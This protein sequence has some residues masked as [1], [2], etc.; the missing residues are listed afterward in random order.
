MIEVGHLFGCLPGQLRRELV[1]E[2]SEL[3]T[4]YIEGKWRA[5]GL[6]AGRFCEVIYSVIKGHS[7]NKYPEKT[8]KPS[9]FIGK[10]K[11]L[12]SDNKLPHAFRLLIPRILATLYEIRNHRNISHVGGAVDPSFMDAS[13]VMANAK[14]LMAELVREFHDLTED[15]AQSIVDNLSQYTPPAVWSDS[16]VRRVLDTKLSFDE[17]ILA[18]LV[19]AGGQADRD[20]LFLWLDQGSK[21]Y[22]NERIAKLHTSRQ[23]EAKAFGG[24]LKLL[25]PGLARANEIFTAKLGRLA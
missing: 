15:M 14:W 10:C 6:N 4:S 13:L 7:D 3:S 12:E 24:A 23:L 19:S 16:K 20:E 25:P 17:K 1:S 11:A 21:K 18:L 9:D 5:S 22:F 2:F 8:T